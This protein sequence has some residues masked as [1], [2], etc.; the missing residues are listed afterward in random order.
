VQRPT[1]NGSAQ[2][3]IHELAGPPLVPVYVGCLPPDSNG[4]AT[5]TCRQAGRR[6]QRRKVADLD[7]QDPTRPWVVDLALGTYEFEARV[8]AGDVRTRTGNIR[9]MFTR[10]DLEKKP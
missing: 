2:F 8:E 6:P 4:T 7:P 9:P 1:I 10:I 5:F 3:T